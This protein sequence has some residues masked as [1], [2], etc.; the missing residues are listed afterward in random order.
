MKPGEFTEYMTLVKDIRPQVPRIHFDEV[1]A[2][3]GVGTLGDLLLRTEAANLEAAGHEVNWDARVLL[4]GYTVQR[5]TF[6]VAVDDWM[7]YRIVD[8]DEPMHEG[9][10]NWEAQDLRPN[11]RAYPAKTDINFALLMAERDAEITFTTFR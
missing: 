1:H 11:K 2:Y 7:I 9:A 6:V 8:A 4:Y 10:S 3:D 5:Y